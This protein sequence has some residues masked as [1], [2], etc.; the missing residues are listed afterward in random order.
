M[1]DS[2]DFI[3]FALIE[4]EHGLIKRVKLTD[5]KS[6]V[7]RTKRAEMLAEDPRTPSE[8]SVSPIGEKISRSQGSLIGPIRYQ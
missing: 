8:I 7:I 4:G 2:Q 1:S 3:K 5:T 6:W